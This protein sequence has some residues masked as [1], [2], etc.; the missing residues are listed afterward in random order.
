ME[1]QNHGMVQVGLQ[2]YQQSMSTAR[3]LF[4]GMLV[5]KQQLLAASG[6]DDTAPGTSNIFATENW[7]GS[8]WT[9]GGNVEYG[10]KIIWLEQVLQTAGLIFGGIGGPGD[11]P[12]TSN[13]KMEWIKLDFS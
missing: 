6:Y 2:L 11:L 10:Q 7:N 13:R 3:R 5:L 1:L 8:A 4:S 9:A 12:T